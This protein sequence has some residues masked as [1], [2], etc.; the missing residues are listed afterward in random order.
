MPTFVLI[1]NG[2]KLDEY[3]GTDVDIIRSLID[4]HVL[5]FFN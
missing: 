4:K 5:W 3:T 1:K 2:E